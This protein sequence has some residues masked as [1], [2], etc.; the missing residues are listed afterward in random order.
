MKRKI[1]EIIPPTPHPSEDWDAEADDTPVYIPVRRT[2]TVEQW[3]MLCPACGGRPS[4]CPCSYKKCL[5][6][7]MTTKPALFRA[8]HFFKKE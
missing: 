4:R 2:I 1:R 5:C 7:N 6:G 3:G 8:T